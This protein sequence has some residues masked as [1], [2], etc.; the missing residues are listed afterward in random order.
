VSGNYSIIL[1]VMISNTIAYLISL[2]YQPVPVFDLLS[3]QDGLELPSLEEVREEEPIRVEDAM[4]SAGAP[5]LRA[6]KSVAQIRS[7]LEKNQQEWLLIYDKD[8]GWHLVRRA[9]LLETI[10][11]APEHLRLAE[12]F[13]RNWVP[14]VH[15]DNSLELPLRRMGELPY[16]PVVHRAHGERL[17]GVVSREDILRA[18]AKMGEEEVVLPSPS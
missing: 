6:E 12:V 13:P 18:Y 7:E 8:S 15:P 10:S 14:T 17:V 16:L 4:R 1:P 11:G 2:K 9:A 3:K 5:P